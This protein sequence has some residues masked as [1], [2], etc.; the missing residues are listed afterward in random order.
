MDRKFD[1]ENNYIR[2]P[3]RGLNVLVFI[4]LLTS[5]FFQV[6]CA[7]HGFSPMKRGYLEIK[8]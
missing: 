4:L 5:L 7:T 6:Y 2:L 1:L 8:Q 3:I